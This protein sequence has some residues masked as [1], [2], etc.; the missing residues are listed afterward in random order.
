MEYLSQ[1]RMLE[2]E[3]SDGSEIRVCP[4]APFHKTTF[5]EMVLNKTGN[6]MYV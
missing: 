6:V 5:F 2:T 1:R 4:I 3:A